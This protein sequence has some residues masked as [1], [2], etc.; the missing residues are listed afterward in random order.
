MGEGR[1]VVFSTAAFHARVS[2]HSFH[3]PQEVILIQFS[4]YV[5]KSCLKTDSFHFYLSENI[6][7][8]NLILT[9]AYHITNNI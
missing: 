7:Y 2:F 8:N 4:L 3:H 5:H 1:R 9:A 6:K